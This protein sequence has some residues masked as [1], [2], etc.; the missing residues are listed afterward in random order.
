MPCILR[1]LHLCS[2]SLSWNFSHLYVWLS[3]YRQLYAQA[4]KYC[5][6]CWRLKHSCHVEEGDKTKQNNTCNQFEDSRWIIFPQESG[7]GLLISEMPLPK[8]S[9]V[10]KLLSQS[11]VKVPQSSVCCWVYF[12]EHKQTCALSSISF[13]I[14]EQRF[15]RAD[16]TVRKNNFQHFWMIAASR[17]S[18]H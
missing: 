8:V 4:L 7:F 13:R 17:T 5:Q 16:S 14:A 11:A 10:L 9:R 1:I 12:G 3:I 6:L 18:V 15:E 2:F